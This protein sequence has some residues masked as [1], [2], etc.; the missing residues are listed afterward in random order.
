MITRTLFDSTMTPKSA[1]VPGSQ[2]VNL[3][4]HGM[5]EVGLEKRWVSLPILGREDGS[6]PAFGVDK[7]NWVA[8]GVCL[9]VRGV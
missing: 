4:P 5:D 9:A 1:C 3:H 6:L 2:M 8:L 7:E